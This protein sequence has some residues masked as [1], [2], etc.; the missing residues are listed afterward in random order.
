[1]T[2]AQAIEAILQHWKTGWTAAQPSVPWVTDNE[3]GD[4]AASW[5]R[6]TIQPTAS[7][8]ATMGRAPQRR[9]ARRGQIAVQVF[10]PI[11]QGDALAADLA[12]SVRA[13]LEGERISTSGVD[14]PVC[15]YAGSSSPRQS[16]GVWHMTMVTVPFR[17]DQ[18][19]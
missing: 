17:Y 14:E 6:I 9:W 1:M 11:N 5:V 16:D 15:T 7:A 10:T 12:D 18:H 2:E 13:V 4:A 3:I 8:Q 19:R